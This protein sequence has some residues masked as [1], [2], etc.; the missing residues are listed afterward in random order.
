MHRCGVIAFHDVL[1]RKNIERR[2]VK[3]RW[4]EADW[5]SA[6]R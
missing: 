2:G 1:P 4:I 6:K 3:E 5:K